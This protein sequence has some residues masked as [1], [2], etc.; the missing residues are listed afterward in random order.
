MTVIHVAGL[1]FLRTDQHLFPNVVRNESVRTTV[2]V[3]D[4]MIPNL[5]R[6]TDRTD[7]LA[8]VAA[9]HPTMTNKTEVFDSTF[10]THLY[11]SESRESLMYVPT[12]SF[13]SS[14]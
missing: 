5:F 1:G 8:E 9:R 2:G 13:P 14:I 10:V 3:V 12:V 11:S 6:S 7:S 4:F